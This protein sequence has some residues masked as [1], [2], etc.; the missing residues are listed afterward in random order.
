M[1]QVLIVGAGH[2][3]P[4]GPFAFLHAMTANERVHVKGLFFRP[5]DYSALAAAGASNNI[6]PF[7]ELE[8][9]EKELI[10]H[11]KA[12]FAHQCKECHLPFSLHD[13]DGE[14]N[15]NL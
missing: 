13:N 9:N 15:K 1:K 8:D 4:K 5:V 2:Q 12:L 3:F 7:L 6:T 10:D 14:W 11:H